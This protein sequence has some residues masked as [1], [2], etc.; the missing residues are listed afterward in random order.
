MGERMSETG[1]PTGKTEQLINKFF[2]RGNVIWP[3][4]DPA[5][6]AGQRVKPYLDLL[7]APD[8]SEVPVMLPRR[9]STGSPLVMYVVARDPQRAT[10]V[11]DLLT[12]F[13][14]P[15]FSYF[16]GLPTVLDDSDPVEHAVREYAADDRLTLKVVLP[17]GP[18]E[19]L[20]WG[21]LRLLQDTLRQRPNREWH[22]RRPVGKLIGEFEAA[23]AAGDVTA[24][25]ALLEEITASGGLSGANL[26]ALRIKR[27]ARLGYDAELLRFPGLADV[28]DTRPPTLVRDAI[29]AAI[30]RAELAG[31][32][33][34]GGPQRTRPA[35]F[36]RGA[37]IRA[38]L[39]GGPAALAGLSGEALTVAAL[40]ADPLE[41]S[42]LV[43]AVLLDPRLLSLVES[44]APAVA[45]SLT[46]ASATEEA[47]SGVLSPPVSTR[48]ADGFTE[49]ATPS[50]WSELVAAIAI[51]ADVTAV[52]AG[53]DWRQWTRPSEEDE[54]I[55]EALAGLGDR[56]ADR[57]WL[58][59]G[60]IVDADGYA[61]PATRTARQLIEIALVG[62]R[63]G[64][65]DL[66]AIIALTEIYM[67][68]SP[69]PADYA[70]LLDDL[71]SQHRQW[72]G[73]DR[74]TVLLD[75][76]DLLLRAAHPDENARLRLALPLLQILRDHDTRMEPD[77]AQFA[78][79]L[80]AELDVTLDWPDRGDR[81]AGESLVDIP[82][83]RMLLYSLD[84][85]V[86]K[87]AK[88]V[89]RKNAPQVDVRLNHEKDGSPSLKK[90]ARNVDIIVLV[91]RC[92]KHAAT[93]F[94]RQQAAD[95]CLIVE[96]DGS[97]APS[98]VRAAAKALWTRA[99]A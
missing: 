93:G 57:A 44:V 70:G 33:E 17:T 66:A 40:A 89:L 79:E 37:L 7:E 58:L 68:S 60:P 78:R 5:S 52:I 12:A 72:A 19:G 61:R 45:E 32:L 83:T 15:S 34:K 67:R 25:A 16:D 49:A 88:E 62:E 64:P 74:A 81:D 36:R 42:V 84:E 99:T 21:A 46:P 11:A 50:S 18:K 75:L 22:V 97:R 13:V 69:S 4:Q 30:Y 53:E 82:P 2:G 39:A 28:A 77:Q 27:L 3:D 85:A 80:S 86:L 23:L 76:I 94:I 38:L 71:A 87:Q 92:A 91:T 9:A 96:A 26:A 90:Q 47:A 43:A 29:L 8:T 10:I 56:E 73:A 63:F 1:E 95:D 59:A 65:G 48:P 6:A 55:A 35:L 51:G 14:G 98:V 20:A 24:S 54:A 41:D 31:L